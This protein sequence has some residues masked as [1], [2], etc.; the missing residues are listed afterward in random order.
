[1]SA[2][3]RK[4]R[5]NNERTS[6]AGCAGLRS[7]LTSDAVLEM[8]VDAFVKTSWS[9]HGDHPHEVAE[10]I[11]TSLHLV[12]T[13][14]QLAPFARLLTHVYGEHLGRWDRGVE[15]LESLRGQFAAAGSTAAAGPI[16]LGVAMLRY[17][18]G[19]ASALE[20]LPEVDRVCALASASSALA[21]R[22]EFPRAIAAYEQALHTAQGAAAVSPS[23]MR[24]LAAGGNSL[25]ALLE[26]KSNRSTSQTQAM[27]EAAQAALLY[28]KQVGTWLEEERAEYR[29]ARSRLQAGQS[30]A[31]VQSAQRCVAVCER[32]IAP[33]FEQFF[34]HSVLASSHRAAGDAASFAAHRE[35]ALSYFEQTSEDERK[36]CETE[37]NELGS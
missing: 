22:D 12:Q 25:A 19:D 36:S 24:A 31:A 18:N 17:G 5:L 8:T 4:A 6:A 16:D 21:G 10:R 15:L 34:A 23:A 26:A 20:A 37:R 13:P 11:A 29:L 35:I 28:W 2:A 33:A 27:L 3:F 30:K 9:D 7:P 14:E 1:M 32:N